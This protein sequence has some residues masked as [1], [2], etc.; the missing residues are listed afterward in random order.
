MNIKL[1]DDLTDADWETMTPMER[2][3]IRTLEEVNCFAR[4]TSILQGHVVALERIVETTATV[5]SGPRKPKFKFREEDKQHLLV[6]VLNKI[7]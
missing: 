5:M 7:S 1:I 2:H 4:N 6:G 3:L